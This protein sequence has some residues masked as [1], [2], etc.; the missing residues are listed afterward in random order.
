MTEGIYVYITDL[1]PGI[2]E[3]VAP[4][5]DGYSV[6]L[7]AKD[8]HEQRQKS[9]AHALRHIA[10]NDFEKTDVQQIEHEAHV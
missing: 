8:T 1:P 5:A 6:Y 7:D 4:C 2:N 3:M 10:G 9:Y